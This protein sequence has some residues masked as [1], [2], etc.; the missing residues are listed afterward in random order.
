VSFNIYGQNIGI[1]VPGRVRSNRAKNHPLNLGPSMVY[2]SLSVGTVPVN[3][4]GAATAATE[5]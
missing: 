1:E 2:W 5:C 3:G 4:K